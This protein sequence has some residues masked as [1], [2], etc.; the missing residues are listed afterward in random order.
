ALCVI[1]V[2]T[3]YL[4]NPPSRYLGLMI[5]IYAGIDWLFY[6]ATVHVMIRMVDGPVS[7]WVSD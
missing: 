5:A 2:M 6:Q 3:N 4:D 7:R 1:S